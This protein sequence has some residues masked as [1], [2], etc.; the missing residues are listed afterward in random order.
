MKYI[1]KNKLEIVKTFEIGKTDEHIL[2]VKH[3]AYLSDNR[4]YGYN[5]KE[6]M[7]NIFILVA[8]R[9]LYGLRKK[10]QH[11]THI[12]NQT[13]LDFHVVVENYIQLKRTMT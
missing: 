3:L 8:L 1:N 6:S 13:Y 2:G 5:L 10:V 7:V 4:L 9:I 11:L 12:A